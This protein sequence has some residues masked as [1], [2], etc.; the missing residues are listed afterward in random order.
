[1]ARNQDASMLVSIRKLMPVQAIVTLIIALL[2]SAAVAQ[3]EPPAAAAH[4]RATASEDSVAEAR[5]HFARGVEHY[6]EGNFDAALVELERA[7]Q[8][9]PNYKLLYNL[10]QV[11]MERH[12]FAAAIKLL[13]EYLRKGGADLAEERVSAVAEDLER[14]RR[15]VAE[16]TIQVDVRGAEVFVN[17]VSVGLSPLREPVLVNVGMCLVRVEKA[18]YA[19]GKRSLSIVG[20]DRRSVSLTLQPET[21]SLRTDA[22]PAR[23]TTPNLTPFWISLGAVAVLGGTTATFGVLSV[24]AHQ[25]NANVL[26][27]YPG[28]V[29]QL[30]A[31]R[32]RLQTLAALTDGFAAATLVAGALSTY[33]LLSASE[34]SEAPRASGS[35]LQL[36]PTLNGASLH[37][38]F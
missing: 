23:A 27:S 22:S 11:Q 14:L 17:Q 13:N 25:H 6:G 35:G 32:N 15:R 9:S 19:P 2:S 18:G 29:S 3:A 34:P 30:D 37:A 7:Q 28:R 24:N 10:A 38:A 4:A 21:T 1:M 20:A 5:L 33:F 26:A 31:A 8:L 36:T 12:D 16:L